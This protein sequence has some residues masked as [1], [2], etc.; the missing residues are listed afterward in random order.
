MRLP[1][2]CRS[3]YNTG[4]EYIV[5]AGRNAAQPCSATIAR[6]TLPC[7]LIPTRSVPP[8]QPWRKQGIAC[9]HGGPSSARAP[10]PPTAERL[11]TINA[12]V[13]SHLLGFVAEDQYLFFA[14][15]CRAWRSA[16]G[17]AQ[18]PAATSQAGADSSL[19]QLRESLASG[20]P[21]DK[22]GLSA[23]LARHGKLELLQLARESGCCAWGPVTCAA[24]AGAGEL[25]LLQWC[26]Y[27]GCPWDD[28]TLTEA[29][30]GGHVEV[31]EWARGF[32]CDVSAGAPAAAAAAGNLDLLKYLIRDGFP[33]GAGVCG[34]AADAG[35]LEV[36]QYLVENDCPVGEMTL[37]AAVLKDRVAVLEWALGSGYEFETL[38]EYAF[39]DAVQ[40]GRF[41]VVRCLHRHG[42]PW[43]G[44][45]C[46]AAAVEGGHD[47]IARWVRENQS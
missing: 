43:D 11:A 47:E 13:L 40:K 3:I 2:T 31:L 25:E 35:H 27:N 26:K 39:C 10:L 38:G 36:L 19:S 22:P 46:L 5:P 1:G 18:R 30:R 33:C 23:A 6:N 8:P 44:P 45:S 14:T 28:R 24:A 29:A 12:D 32:G 20:V 42:C 7:R 15:A 21:I 9:A 16:W 4:T 37:F 17:A 34:A 41:A